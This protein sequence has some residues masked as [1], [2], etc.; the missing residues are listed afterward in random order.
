MIRLSSKIQTD[1]IV[2]GEG[3]RT[4]IWTQGCPHNCAGCHNKETHSF[5]GGILVDIDDIKKQIDNLQDQDGITLSGGDPLS[6]IDACLEIAKYVK[7]KKLNIWCYTGYTYEQ[8]IKMG[9]INKKYL[10]FL[11]YID[12][13]VDGKFE[14][15]KKS[16]NL[17]FKG[18]SNQ[19]I[20][21]VNKTLLEH[22]I[23]LVRK[24]SAIKKCKP[25]YKQPAHIFT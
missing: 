3:I 8:I 4:V 6:Q 9:N 22:K 13:L 11:L 21:D 23:C 24:Y 1:S 19:R 16:L 2:D 12:V 18:S 7:S 15:D 10:E 20:I 25:L 5:D 17:K 14:L